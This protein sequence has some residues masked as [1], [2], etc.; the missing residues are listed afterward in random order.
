MEP[1]FPLT[2]DALREQTPLA[3]LLLELRAFTTDLL[4]ALLGGPVRS[5]ILKH[6]RRRAGLIRRNLLC[7]NGFPLF[8]AVS[9]VRAEGSPQAHALVRSLL[10]DRGLVLGHALNDRGLFGAKTK[11]LFRRVSYLPSYQALFRAD[12]GAAEVWERSY[13]ILSPKQKKIAGVTEIFSPRLE[14]WMR[15]HSDRVHTTFEHAARGGEVLARSAR[16]ASGPHE[17]S[18]TTFFATPRTRPSLTRKN[19][20]SE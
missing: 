8:L 10:A 4:E 2:E 16:H 15:E 5:M 9:V 14:Q 18:S 12:G 3:P 17:R 11:P 20:D 7:A 13:A 6:E 19:R 1:A